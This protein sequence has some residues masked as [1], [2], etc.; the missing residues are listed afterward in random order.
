MVDA[1]DDRG[2]HI[3][4]ARRGDDDFFG[5]TRQVR[6]GFVLTREQPGRFVNDV[7]AEFAP[8]QF[9]RIAFGEHLDTV[10]VDDHGIAVHS[11]FTRETAVRGI[12]FREMG[13]GRGIAQIV[14]GNDLNLAGA[15]G[16][17]QRPQHVT[18]DAPVAIDCDFDWHLTFL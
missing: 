1:V 15:L 16:F 13:V 4:A 17:V 11:N 14:H 3:F 6:G 5:P 2:V 7:D 12:V 10:T 18:P 9:G 8:R